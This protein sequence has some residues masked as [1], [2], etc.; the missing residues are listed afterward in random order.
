V[1]VGIDS[2]M[3]ANCM[4]LLAQ[5]DLDFIMTS[6]REWGCYPALPALSI[7]QLSTRPGFNAVGITQ[8]RW[9]GREK[10]RANG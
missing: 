8:W 7:C 6:E 1:F 9:N 2:E 4:E 3:R 10:K 5:F